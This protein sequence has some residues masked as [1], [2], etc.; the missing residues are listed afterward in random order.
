MDGSVG[1]AELP[2]LPRSSATMLAPLLFATTVTTAAPGAPSAA[3][4]AKEAAPQDD[5]AERPLIRRPMPAPT[6]L[7]PGAYY[8]SWT[9]LGDRAPA[10]GGGVE[11]SL[12]RWLPRSLFVLGA[13]GDVE[14]VGHARSALG[15]E[16]GYD[17]VGLELAV[18]RDFAK[19]DAFDA[20]WSLQIGTYVS[21]GPLFIAPRWLLP[22][23]RAG[24]ASPGYGALLTVG[25]KIP[26]VLSE[27]GP[28][29]PPPGRAPSP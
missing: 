1:R 2:A 27:G 8:S 21:V 22:L 24:E 13:F 10:T 5:W 29:T 16:V 28:A 11:L 14:Y 15:V 23:H 4:P 26:V 18:A 3:E 19:G 9:P 20:Q 12:A 7:L 25:F 17:V 6:F